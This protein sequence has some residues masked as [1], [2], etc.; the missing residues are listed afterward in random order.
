MTGENFDRTTGGFADT[1]QWKLIV[2][3][4]PGRISA[5]LQNTLRP[6]ETPVKVLERIWE[7]EED[8]L[9][10]NIESAFYDNPGM[11]DDFATLI[12]IDTFKSLWIPEEFTDDEDFDPKYF[13]AVYPAATED[14]SADFAGEEVNLYTLAPGLT[15]F[16]Q[17]TMPGC[18][19]SSSH[20]ILKSY[21]EKES[22][23]EELFVN[24]SAPFEADLFAFKNGHMLSGTKIEWKE[25]SDLAYRIILLTQSYGLDRNKITLKVF[26][27]RESAERLEGQL[28]ELIGNIEIMPLPQSVIELDA[29]LAA[30]VA[31]AK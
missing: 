25:L 27:E 30:S 28:T 7:Q 22:D 6:E 16:L 9:L 14:I 26:A 1:G 19:I 5:L 24:I 20:S 8:K 3:I 4:A 15:S 2:F 11:L 17:R 13:T 12:I 18:R 31:A 29:P 23:G 21:F 10:N